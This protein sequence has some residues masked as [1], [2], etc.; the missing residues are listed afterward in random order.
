MEP[1]SKPGRSRW[2]LV[3]G[4]GVA[5]A[6]TV[7]IAYWLA[8]S[9]FADY[10]DEGAHLQS[11]RAFL[12]GAPLYTKLYAFHGPF[13]YLLVSALYR[14]S[15]SAATTDGARFVVIAV[16]CCSA[17]AVG[18]AVRRVTGSTLLGIAGQIA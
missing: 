7:L 5:S 13:N 2:W 6:A 10:D 18:L 4:F 17:L 8:F 3:A 9:T 11:V 12:E 1:G 15:L 16:W 14:F